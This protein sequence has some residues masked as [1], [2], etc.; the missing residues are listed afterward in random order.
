MAETNIRG[1]GFN[2]FDAVAAAKTL[3]LADSGVVQ[4]VTASATVTLPAVAT[5]VAGTTY[6]VQVGGY[7]L[8]VVIDVAAADYIFGG[9][10]ATPADGKTITFT[11]QP[12]GSFV[13]LVSNGTV[14]F[15]ISEVNGTFVREA[16]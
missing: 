16:A 10:I 1:N 12:A 14:G 6:I 15:G 7:G 13:K 8:T 9:N 4:K 11:N 3:T 5:A 2:A